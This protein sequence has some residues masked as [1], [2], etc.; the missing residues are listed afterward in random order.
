MGGILLIK[1]LFDSRAPNPNCDHDGGVGTFLEMMGHKK[2][3]IS[4]FIDFGSVCSLLLFMVWMKKVHRCLVMIG[5]CS[6]FLI[7]CVFL[8]GSP[9]LSEFATVRNKE[10]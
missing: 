1:K 3:K 2:N 10:V 7:W 6:W 4:V 5:Q 8:V 9:I